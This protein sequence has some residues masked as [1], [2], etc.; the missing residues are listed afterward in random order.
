MNFKHHSTRFHNVIRIFPKL[1]V[2]SLLLGALAFGSAKVAFG[3]PGRPLPGNPGFI[4]EFDETGHG[5]LITSVLVPNPGVPQPGGGLEYFLPVSV[6]PGD[7][8]VYNVEDVSSSN[9]TGFSDLLTFFNSGGSG[10]LLYRSLQDEG[11]PFPDLADVL[12]LADPGTP[13]SVVES[14][15]EGNNGFVWFAGTSSGN[16]DYTVYNGISDV[17]EPS[18]FVLGGLGLVGLF[19]IRKRVSQRLD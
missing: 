6:T 18:T 2:A 12:G 1:G 5:Q 11:E 14:G 16:P 10:I 9:P 13:F 8:A 17:P 4:L 3:Q 7:V 19:L 15:P